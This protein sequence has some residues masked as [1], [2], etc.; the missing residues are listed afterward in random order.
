MTEIEKL[1][2]EEN[3]EPIVLYN[4]NEE[5]VEFEQVAVIPIDG[6]I[7]AILKPSL[8]MEGVGEDEVLI[9]KLDYDDDYED[10]LTLVVS[11]EE[12]DAVFEVYERLLE[13]T[14]E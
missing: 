14:Q 7:Y 3:N 10:C 4:E 1:L 6:I 2:D 12:I 8:P 5:P 11:D 13:E 9:F